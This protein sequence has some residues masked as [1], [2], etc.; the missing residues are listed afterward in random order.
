MARCEIS[1]IN[2]CATSDSSLPSVNDGKKN[3]KERGKGEGKH[4]EMLLVT[5]ELRGD[6]SCSLLL[7]WVSFCL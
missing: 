2:S 3:S 1:L 5:A 6:L 7:A 4:P